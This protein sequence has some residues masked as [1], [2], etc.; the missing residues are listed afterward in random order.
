MKKAKNYLMM[1]VWLL[2]IIMQAGCSK[3][4]EPSTRDMLIGEWEL[5][6]ING[7]NV[8]DFV[9]EITVEADGDY[10]EVITF[11]GSTSTYRGEWQLVGKTIEIE[12]DDGDDFELTIEEVTSTK[13]VVE[14]E[15]N[16]EYE[17][18]KI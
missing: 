15:D 1:S 6:E 9:M 5:D 13:L 18:D 14:D 17:F 11:D 12:Y 2:L 7:Q 8:S 16:D 10:K 4:D 3:D